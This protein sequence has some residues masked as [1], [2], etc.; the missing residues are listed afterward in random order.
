MGVRDNGDT[1][2][3]TGLWVPLWGDII[4]SLNEW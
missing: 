1:T 4:F 2:D 3:T